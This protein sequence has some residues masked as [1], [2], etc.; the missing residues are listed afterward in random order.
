MEVTR[1]WNQSRLGDLDVSFLKGVGLNKS[2]FSDSG[3]TPGIHYG[4]LFTEYG[5]IID[6][7]RLHVTDFN[8]SVKSRKNDVLM[9]TSDVTPNGL[10]KA[11]SVLADDIVLG[12]DIL[13]IR[14]NPNVIFGPYLSHFIRF[15]PDQIKTLVSGSTVYHIY[16]KDLREFKIF[17][18]DITEQKAI[19]KALSDI[20]DLIETLVKEEN[21]HRYI[22]EGLLAQIDDRFSETSLLK[23]CVASPVTDGPHLTPVFYSSGVPFLS[24]NNIVD[25]KIV[26]ENLRYISESDDLE[27]SRK[28]KPKKFDILLGKAASVGKVAIVDSD[29]DFNVWSPLAVIRMNE[30]YDPYFVYFCFQTKTVMNQINFLTNSSSQGNIG[31][32]DI[33]NIGLPMIEKSEQIRLGNLLKDE[34]NQIKGVSKLRHKYECIKQGMAH[35][36][37]TGKVRLV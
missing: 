28:C 9:P 32:G 13:V 1:N 16:A 36:L 3:D 7:V 19:A 18:P 12:G 27:F 22:K 35:D 6:R 21:K 33:E 25:N 29:T 11:S 8:G 37:L 24:V 2:S 5:P 20:D 31:M 10:A 14:A 4:Q 15:S 26:W 23:E 34:D 17:L 30:K